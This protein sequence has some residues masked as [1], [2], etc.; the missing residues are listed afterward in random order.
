MDSAYSPLQ[1]SSVCSGWLAWS[2]QEVLALLSWWQRAWLLGWQGWCSGVSLLST[3]G[4]STWFTQCLQL[5]TPCS[6]CFYFYF[7]HLHHVFFLLQVRPCRDA[8]CCLLGEQLLG[9]VGLHSLCFL[10]LYLPPLPP[11]PHLLSTECLRL[12]LELHQVN[13]PRRL[14]QVIQHNLETG[15]MMF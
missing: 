13:H 6:A 10:H 4:S 3:P 9:H 1:L 8:V 12:P 15:P 5:S 11:H 2:P 7:V 14:S